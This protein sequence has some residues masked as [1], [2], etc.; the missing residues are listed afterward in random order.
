MGLRVEDVE[1]EENSLTPHGR[2]V[3]TSKTS[4]SRE[5]PHSDFTASPTQRTPTGCF[6]A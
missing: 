6:Q 5:S 4:L 1:D 3:V 2:G